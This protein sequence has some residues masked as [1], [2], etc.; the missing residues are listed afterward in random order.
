MKRQQFHQI[1]FLCAGIYNLLWG[2]YSGLDPQWFFRYTGL[3]LLNH[4]QIFACLGMVVGV[5]G[6][7][8]LEIARKPAAGFLIGAIGLLG[9]LLGP[10]GWAYLYLSDTWPLSS[11]VLILTN[12]LIWW[13]P[14]TI[15]LRDTGATYFKEIRASFNPLLEILQEG[16]VR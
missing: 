15:Y 8:Y 9:K 3:P 14:F 13:I 7:L 6:I 4:P 2:A 10:I 1:T 12:D 11:I 5:Y 16:S